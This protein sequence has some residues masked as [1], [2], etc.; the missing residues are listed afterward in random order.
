[1]TGSI[2]ELLWVKYHQNVWPDAV[3]TFVLLLLGF[4][5][6]VSKFAAEAGKAT[7][8]VAL[9]ASK[10]LLAADTIHVFIVRTLAIYPNTD[11][12]SLSVSQ[13]G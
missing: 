3:D 9:I 13:A 7:S 10:V 6:T 1:M 5:W 8:S 2:F 12:L 11:L 4:S